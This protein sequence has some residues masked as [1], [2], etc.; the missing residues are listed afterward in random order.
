M[1]RFRNWVMG[2]TVAASWLLTF[3]A[4]FTLSEQ[5]RRFGKLKS[6]HD[7]LKKYIGDVY[8]NPHKILSQ[9]LNVDNVRQYIRLKGIRWPNIVW[10]QCMVE[11][12]Y[13]TCTNCCLQKNNLFGFMIGRKCMEFPNWQSSVDYYA[14][15]Q[16]RN[17]NPGEDY[18]AFLKRIGYAEFKDYR[19]HVAQI[20]LDNN[21][22]YSP[23]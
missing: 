13:L 8:A 17:M 2:I 5:N 20:L 12:G 9:T 3:W 22:K 21:L 1:R 15:W 10:A 19:I 18:F 11:T 14:R 4:F 23:D 6:E 16:I 7:S